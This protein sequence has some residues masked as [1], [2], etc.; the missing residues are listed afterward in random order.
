MPSD[1]PVVQIA[2]RWNTAT[3]PQ[4]TSMGSE[5]TETPRARAHHV[6][7]PLIEVDLATE[8]QV[9]RA[10]DS[11][12][13]ADHAAKTIAK[14]P[15]IRVVL[16]ALKPGGQMHEHH[17]DR[18]ITVQGIDGHVEFTVGERVVALTPGRLLTV[19]P[20]VPHRVRGMDESAF[21]LTI[22]GAHDRS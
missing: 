1:Y 9:V 20:G 21:L 6:T 16:I 12:H 10:G 2:T 19:P 8:L 4:E 22:G 17:A 7:D 13:A 14:H 11:Y 18:A 3:V 15:G 5:T